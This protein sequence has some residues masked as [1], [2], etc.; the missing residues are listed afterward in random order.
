MGKPNLYPLIMTFEV[1]GKVSDHSQTQ[2]GI[3]EVTSEVNATGGRAFHINGKNILIRGGGWT[4]DMMLRE[5]S[6]RL[7]D[8]LRYVRDMGLNTVRLEGKLETRNFS[9]SRTAREFW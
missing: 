7:Q 4:P 1:N 8:E 9:I 6:Q 2:F 3:R 5:S